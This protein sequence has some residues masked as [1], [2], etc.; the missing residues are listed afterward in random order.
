VLC[1][2]HHPQPSSLHLQAAAHRITATPIPGAH[3]LVDNGYRGSRLV[4]SPRE[5]AAC[6]QGN[7][8]GGEIPRP[9]LVVIDSELLI[10]RGPIAVGG[11]GS[12]RI[13]AIAEG[14]SSRKRS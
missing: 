1:H 3:G 2:A 8:H 7:A 5:L 14:N 13:I 12:G 9:H 6:P 10:G 4:V 11:H